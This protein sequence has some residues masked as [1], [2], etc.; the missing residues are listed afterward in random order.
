VPLAV[1]GQGLFPGDVLP[2]VLPWLPG[3]DGFELDDPVFGVEPDAPFAVPG[4]V[5][6]GEPL[7]EV[8]GVF[9]V[10]GVFGLT[11]DGCVVLPGV[12]GF[13]EF[14]PGTV[15]LGVPLGEVEPGVVW[16]VVVPVCGVEVPV[17]GFTLPVGGV[18]VVPGVELCRALPEPPAGAAPPG[19]LWA[20]A[21]LA[22]HNTTDNNVSFRDDMCK[23]SRRFDSSF[24][25][26]QLV[27]RGVFRS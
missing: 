22:Q 23:T 26:R 25:Y 3:V 11:V 19:E 12:A 1:G 14:D 17:G 5:P 16:G 4:K 20:M 6:H 2:L 13:G 9:G 15:V 7:G 27:D 24:K 10:F 18:A 8:P 21:Q